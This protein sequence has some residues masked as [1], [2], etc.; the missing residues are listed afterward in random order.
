MKN[1]TIATVLWKDHIGVYGSPMIKNPE[2][3]TDKLTM[4]IGII[5]KQTKNCV[6]LVSDIDPHED[7]D[8]CNYTII[9]KSAIV[10]TQEYGTIALRKLRS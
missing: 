6:V 5:Y 7:I 9:L 1:Y 2:T 4:S 8:Q 3:E 10:A